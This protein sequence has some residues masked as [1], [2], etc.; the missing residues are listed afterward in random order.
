ML[1]Q[2]SHNAENSN[3]WHVSGLRWEL[4]EQ[5]L[6]LDT[7]EWLSSPCAG[8]GSYC[9]SNLPLCELKVESWQ[10]LQKLID[11]C[12]F[13]GMVP[14]LKDNGEW[15]LFYQVPCRY[16]HEPT[17]KC[18]IHETPEQSAICKKYPPHRCWYKKAFS[19]P[20]SL[21]LIR[22]NAARL[23]W[24]IEMIGFDDAGR[25]DET[26]SWEVMA[27]E[28][29]K[30]RFSPPTFSAP[31]TVMEQ[32]LDSEFL[33]LFP[34]DKPKSI[35]HFDLVR[36]RMGFPGVM[37]LTSFSLW[38]FSVPAVPRKGVPAAMKKLLSER[39]AGGVYDS[40]IKGIDAQE[41]Y[42]LDTGACSRISDF[43]D[44]PAFEYTKK[45]EKP[46]MWEENSLKKAPVSRRKRMR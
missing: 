14:A 3:A 2:K 37:V 40:L 20:E 46:S 33:L 29:Q 27:E 11:L 8:C 28:L 7:H 24:L 21:Q 22:F 35:E 30:I 25:I 26:P 16:I 18:T 38:C 6:F 9:C 43:Q 10:D 32:H 23:G 19:S 4:D 39:V 31:P 1:S 45:V 5:S 13:E 44:L 17:G 36:F 34:P 12:W 15:K 41:R 42:L